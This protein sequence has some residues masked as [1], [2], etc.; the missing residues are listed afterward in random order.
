M[1]SESPST[2]KKL[3]SSFS[4]PEFTENSDSA[5]PNSSSN[6]DSMLISGAY[7]NNTNN[8][9]AAQHHIHGLSSTLIKSNTVTSGGAAITTTSITFNSTRDSGFSDSLAED[10]STSSVCTTSGIG[11][12]NHLSGGLV[13]HILNVSADEPSITLHTKFNT[14]NGKIKLKS[15]EE[16]IDI[17]QPNGESIKIPLTTS[18]GHEDSHNKSFVTVVKTTK[19]TTKVN[20]KHGQNKR[21]KGARKSKSKENVIVLTSSDSNSDDQAESKQ[22]HDVEIPIVKVDVNKTSEEFM[23][24]TTTDQPQQ[25][26]SDSQSV[27]SS[28][29]ITRTVTTTTQQHHHHHHHDLNATVLDSEDILS[30]YSG[31][32]MNSPRTEIKIQTQRPAEVSIPVEAEKA[33]A[34]I[35]PAVAAKDG[36]KK[37]KKKQKPGT[38][39][40]KTTKCFQL[41]KSSKRKADKSSEPT[42]K[43]IRIEIT[44][45]TLTAAA[46]QQQAISSP[47]VS[48]LSLA[49]HE[50]YNI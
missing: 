13:Q 33:P 30:T 16:D 10:L 26:V 8:N 12:G 24:E 19:V 4:S 28:S 15:V 42:S 17:I 41:K 25:Q 22:Q 35:K 6:L 18:A 32:Q 49:S 2:N 37:D 48:P 43:Q 34:E 45:P 27:I 47:L 20:K 50:R 46:D 3:P 31:S 21:S 23:F 7:A 38:K 5:L 29:I 44:P 11:G 40:P 36:S 14:D 9:T 1:S 39:S